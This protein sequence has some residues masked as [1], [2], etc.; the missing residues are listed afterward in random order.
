MR[1]LL[2]KLIIW[3]LAAEPPP[4]HDAAGMDK[5]ASGQKLT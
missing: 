2:R 5:I 4:P 3:A 1:R